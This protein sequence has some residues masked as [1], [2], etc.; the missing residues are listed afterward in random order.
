[1]LNNIR[2]V[3]VRTFHP[4]NIGSAAR[5]M[6]TMGLSELYLV[7]P[8]DFETQ[9]A[10][11]EATKMST[12]AD[13]IVQSSTL[14]DSVFEAVKDCTVVVASTAR[15]RGYDLPLLNPQETAEKLYAASDTEKVALVFGPERMGLSNE[16]LSLCKYRATIPTNPDYSSLN[17]AAAVQTFSYEIFK[18]HLKQHIKKQE[19]FSENLPSSNTDTKQ[20]KKHDTKKYPSTE[21]MDKF[22][23]HLEQTLTETN[24]IIKNHP[25][26]IMQKLQAMFNRAEM[27]ET[28]LNIMR[29]ILASIQR[30]LND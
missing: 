16:D 30:E 12:S 19:A 27:D 18:Q 26:E 10:K 23:T 8:K 14:V 15:T 13:D 25:G 21:N 4:G 5:A 17:I 2:V 9:Q 28:E 20:D 3:L 7:A 29:G 1:M 22:Y 6:K 11:D 24:F